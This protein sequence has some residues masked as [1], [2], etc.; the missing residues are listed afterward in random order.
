MS[1][2]FC[3]GR[4]FYAE[5]NYA[6]QQ[7]EH[8]FPLTEN[9]CSAFREVLTVVS[10]VVRVSRNRGGNGRSRSLAADQLI[11]THDAVAVT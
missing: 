1:L 2:R 8:M 7:S 6:H 4:Y 10:V 3:E 5:L 9:S 11:M